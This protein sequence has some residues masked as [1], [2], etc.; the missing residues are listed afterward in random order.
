MF[1]PERIASQPLQEEPKELKV[2]SIRSYE[3][4]PVVTELSES[5][6]AY[7]SQITP[8]TN[9]CLIGD[10]QGMDTK[11]FLL[12]GVRPENI[13][14]INYE[15]SEVDQANTEVLQ[16]T[17]VEM[18]QGD[19]TSFESLEGAGLTENSQELITL[20]HV[21]EVPNIKG[22]TEKNLIRN[23][24]K[25]LKLG[26][27]VLVSQYKHK[28]TKDER[29]LQKQIGIEEITTENLQ[30]QFGDNWREKFKE[31]YSLEWEEGMRYGEISNVRTKE[32]L[33][34][35]FEQDFDV[36]IEET[37]SE[38]ILKMKKK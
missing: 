36:N 34:A 10:G 37:E 7:E 20:M 16:N 15:Q 31:E 9:V 21:L 25:L 23:I 3:P 12:M 29:D 26:G 33:V 35:L 27:E 28:F 17:G 13:K 19:A 32:E 6:V 30:K 14:S 11:Q 24:V 2:E 18:R 22:D 5:K 38:Y 4:S 1:N 8:E